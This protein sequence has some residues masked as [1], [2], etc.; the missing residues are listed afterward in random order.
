VGQPFAAGVRGRR[1]R[2][3]RARRGFTLVELLVVI[4]IIAVLVAIL[5]PS[6][7][8]A[9][10]QAQ[11]TKC[12]AN[13]RSI[14]QMVAAYENL[15]KGAIPVG[16]WANS[17]TAVP[18]LQNNYGIAFR[19]SGNGPTAVL[20]FNGLG[21]LYPA[22]LVG[23]TG[24]QN[25]LASEGE[26]FYC[27]TMSVAQKDHA[28][29]SP[30]N[31]WINNLILP[32]AGTNLTRSAYSSRAANPVSTKLTTNERGVGWTRTGTWSPFDA[33]GSNPPVIVPML[34]VPQMKSR[35]IVSDIVS[36][37]DR[38][39]VL[40]H[41][42]GIN[43]LYADGSAKWVNYDHFKTQLEAFTGYGTGQNT[44]MEKLWERLDEAP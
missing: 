26:V 1:R 40:C 35:M 28:Y 24:L 44:K 31:P 37:L 16:F 11:R 6:L 29:D 15:F 8:R 25:N 20:R 30:D 38:V 43:V 27:P 12:V 14:G 23:S 9:R 2:P 21:F 3:L 4:G 36:A 42:T 18:T 22:G 41:K 10:E 5:L 39:Q 19:E 7:N 33:T 32:G 13:L 34:R 17:D